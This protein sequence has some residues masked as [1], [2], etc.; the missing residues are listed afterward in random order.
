MRAGY[1]TV[2]VVGAG[3]LVLCA[4]GCAQ[5][6]ESHEPVAT[7]T[8]SP[9]LLPTPTPT[10]T[11][12]DYETSPETQALADATRIHGDES[13]DM[14]ERTCA[15]KWSIAALAADEED[16]Y[17]PDCYLPGVETDA[18]ELEPRPTTTT[19]TAG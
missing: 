9:S 19:R 11:G 17:A 14:D 18:F 16:T 5:S 8:A 13:R 1:R 6:V 12:D 2:G 3:L 7:E 10:P 4:S 15:L